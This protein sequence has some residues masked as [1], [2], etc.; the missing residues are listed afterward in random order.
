MAGALD[1]IKIL[2]MA[3]YISGP[4]ASMLLAD[5]GA[6]VIKVE[7]PGQGDPFR[8]WG[9]N[10]YSPTFC[11]LNRNKKSLS[12]NVQTSEGKK[13]YMRLARDADV[14]IENMRPGVLARMGIG[15]EAVQAVNPGIVYCSIS[16][17][18]S[19]GPYSDRPG[20]DTIGQAMGG[21][22]SVLTDRQRPKGT[23][24]SLSDLLTALY[25][26]YAVQGALLGRERTGRGQKVETSLLQATVAFGAENA[27]RYLATGVVPNQ[28]TRVHMAQVYAFSAADGLPFVIHLSSPQKFW[29]NLAD[30]IGRPELKED[31]RFVNKE[32]RIKNYDALHAILSERFATAPREHWLK[33]LRGLDVP[34]TS[35]LDL[36]EVFEDPQVNHLGMLLEMVHPTKGKV[37]LVGSGIR[38][39]DTPPQ[40]KLPPPTA[41]E[42]TGEILRALGY[43]AE[44]EADLR[45]KG[46]I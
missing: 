44:I 1:G 31:P 15:Y 6:D 7:I 16:G 42:H 8:G 11:S 3:N 19:D 9:D 37:R 39:S 24:A 36:K 46:V 5:L 27:V 23:G 26:C 35:L 32:A 21:L 12:L 41:G 2:E 45:K 30:A 13:I 10:A 18:G 34:S 14:I 29:H 25:A 4:F 38:M 22:L 40:M 33:I 28:N 20:Y 43:G 17:Y